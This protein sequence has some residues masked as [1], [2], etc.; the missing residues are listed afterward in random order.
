M[1][2]FAYVVIPQM[3]IPLLFICC[4]TIGIGKGFTIGTP[5]NYLI[6]LFAPKGE[7]SS[8][9]ATL[10]LMKAIG[11]AMSPNILVGFISKASSKIGPAIVF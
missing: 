4:I 7:S 2:L 10:S 11:I 1:A 8:T 3:S 5:L 9:Q 6:Q